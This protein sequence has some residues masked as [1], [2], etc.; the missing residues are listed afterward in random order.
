MESNG[1][2]QVSRR[3]GFLRFRMIQLGSTSEARGRILQK[4]KS[5]TVQ[6]LKLKYFPHTSLFQA[7]LGSRPSFIWRSIV[8][9]RNLVAEG[10]FWR[11]GN[12]QETRI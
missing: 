12:D 2:G 8:A 11:I 10:S 9:A 4:P 6:I 1:E 7:K 5:L 3:V